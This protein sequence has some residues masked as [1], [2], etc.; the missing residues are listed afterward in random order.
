MAAAEQNINQIIRDNVS[1]RGYFEFTFL[2]DFKFTANVAFDVFNTMQ[3]RFMTPVGGDAK[4]VGG[5]GYKDNSRYFPIGH[6]GF[7]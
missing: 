7:G 3:T 2:K 5:R 1:S 4:N 6:Y